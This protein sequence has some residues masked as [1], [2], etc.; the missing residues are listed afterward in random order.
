MYLVNMIVL[1]ELRKAM[2]VIEAPFHV[3]PEVKDKNGEEI[4]DVR[5]KRL[6]L[7]KEHINKVGCLIAL[8]DTLEGMAEEEIGEWCLANC[9]DALPGKSE[10]KNDRIKPKQ[11]KF[12]FASLV[13]EM[14]KSLQPQ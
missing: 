1:K 6:I 2:D 3:L 7:V 9:P 13:E 10:K 5:E 8:S 4:K 14:N 11:K 12:G